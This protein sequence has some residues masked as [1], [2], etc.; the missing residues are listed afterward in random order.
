MSP[1]EV[2]HPVPEWVMPKVQVARMRTTAAI[3]RDPN[4]VHWDSDASRARGLDGRRINQGP[5]N[6]GYLANMLMAWQG[7]ICVRRLTLQFPDR[8]LEG[9]HI[10]ARGVVIA[11]D[12]REDERLA[13]CEVW[14]ERPDGFRPVVGTAVV[15]LSRS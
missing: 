10:T 7:D 4:P 5:L 9:D 6:V 3:L 1:V 8:V 15:A 11:V 2:G 13:T 14:L 12:N